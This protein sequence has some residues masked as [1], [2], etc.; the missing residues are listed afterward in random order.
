MITLLLL[1]PSL[2][3]VAALLQLPSRLGRKALLPGRDYLQ[4]LRQQAD[5]LGG[6]PASSSFGGLQSIVVRKQDEWFAAPAHVTAEQARHAH[7]LLAVCASDEEAWCK[8]VFENFGVFCL[9]GE[10]FVSIVCI[11]R[12]FFFY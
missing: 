1:Q 11:L 8:F 2:Q 3:C 6:A 5:V 9:C 12:L 7:V 10:N 4:Q